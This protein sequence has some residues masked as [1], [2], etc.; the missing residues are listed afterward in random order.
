[1]I[2]SLR[3]WLSLSFKQVLT[4]VG[5]CLSARQLLKIQSS[6]N[7]LKMGQHL[8]TLGFRFNNR[9]QNRQKV[10]A[11]VAKQIENQRVLYMEFGVAAGESMRYWSQALKHPQSILHGFD[12]FEGLP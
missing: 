4:L 3:R 1:M 5:Q 11:T 2:K 7:Y 10:W 8:A 12:S 6:V 9:V